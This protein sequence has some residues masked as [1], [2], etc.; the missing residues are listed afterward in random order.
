MANEF[1]PYYQWLGIPPK[2]QPPHHYR[3][4]GVDV[5][6]DNPNVIEAAAERQSTY[7]HE[8]STGPNVKES[9][10]LLNE[11]AAARLCLLSP[12]KRAAYD[13]ELKTKIDAAVAVDQLSDI[14]S[15]NSLWDDIGSLEGGAPSDT[16]SGA[17][18]NTMVM[19]SQPTMQPGMQPMMQP[20]MHSPAQMA[21][22][23]KLP[24]VWIG[25]GAALALVVLV[26]IIFQVVVYILDLN[27]RE[28][29]RVDEEGNVVRVDSNLNE[30]NTTEGDGVDL[31][32]D[33]VVGDPADPSS[34]D[35]A[36]D[37]ASFTDPSEFT[38][39]ANPAG[40]PMDPSETDPTDPANPVGVDPADPA[41]NNPV[42]DDPANPGGGD[43][44]AV[45]S[46]PRQNNKRPN[47]NGGKKPPPKPKKIGFIV[48]KPD[49]AVS[50]GEVAIE[51]SEDLII[52]NTVSTEGAV[53]S[54]KT[55]TDLSGITAIRLEAVSDGASGPG[56]GLK[57]KFSIEEVRV[58]ARP[59]GNASASKEVDL[60]GAFSKDVI[61]AE[62]LVDGSS[63]YWAVS[64][65]G[66]TTMVTICFQS[67]I[68]IP[69][70][71]E[72]I[73]QLKQKPKENLGRF[74]IS[75]TTDAEW[76]GLRLP[77]LVNLGGRSTQDRTG[78]WIESKPF[79]DGSVCGHVGGEALTNRQTTQPSD[80]CIQ[81]LTAF[82][83]RVPSGKYQ[84]EMI[85]CEWWDPKRQFS[86]TVEKKHKSNNVKIFELA[87][88]R[89]KEYK[90]RIEDVEVNDGILDIEFKKTSGSGP[91]LNA[92]AIRPQF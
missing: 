56:L 10:K 63:K 82:R 39:P 72:F 14:D 58:E 73:I 9:Q 62:R 45:N 65:P 5:F 54:V 88:G 30:A 4:L 68:T 21:S 22:Q 84:I 61:G 57:G 19:Q 78:E 79:V 2:D 74:R 40:D 35:P 83:A 69:G 29:I 53:Y 37:D 67:K 6:E 51:T 52:A 20:G 24:W 11:I 13:A 28:P 36:T 46:E 77:L 87:R 17:A 89:G 27:N 76:L 86:V 18:A 33:A 66:T 41:S 47:K 8:L 26:V 15:S 81:G 50:T 42:T 12:D 16:L 64:R 70:G 3:L 25:V 38:D 80:S 48:L 92:V 59:V 1:D 75:A 90:A 85:F 71:T 31:S 43:P 44:A 34:A 32:E 55:K 23:R 7:L 49:A 60:S 91:I